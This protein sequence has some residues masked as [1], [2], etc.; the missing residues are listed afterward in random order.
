MI[1]RFLRALPAALLALCTI[2]FSS[3]LA[4]SEEIARSY[5]NSIGMEFVLIPAGTFMMGADKNV[6][7]GN[8][9]EFPRHQ[10]SISNLFYLGVYEVTQRQWKALMDSNHSN[11]EGNDNPVE[12]VS[13]NEAQEFI[14]RLNQKEGHSRYRLPTDA[15]W[16][17]SARAGSTSAYYFGNDKSQLGNYAW[18]QGNSGDTT[19]PVGQKLPNAWG[20]YDM[21]GNVL[22]LTEDWASVDYYANSHS[23]DPTG[24]PSGTRRLS[25]GCSWNY[26]TPECRSANHFSDLPADRRNYIGFRLVLTLEGSE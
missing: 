4:M 3:G 6:E 13:W 8:E 10:V 1:H 11:F 25:R 18:Y 17:Y 14:R 21:H 7:D 23:V 5:T 22:E 24:P 2:V 16:E 15:E 19:H 9:D 12:M 20:L 26:N